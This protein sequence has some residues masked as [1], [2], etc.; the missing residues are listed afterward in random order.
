RDAVEHGG[1]TDADE[2]QARARRP[3]AIGQSVD[4]ESHGETG[5]DRDD[6]HPGATESEHDDGEGRRGA[7]A[8]ADADDVGARARIAQHRLEGDATE[9]EADAGDH[10]ED[11]A[12]KPQ[13]ADREVRAGHVLSEDDAQ[14]VRGRIER[15]A[16][17]QT[18]REGRD[19]EGCEHGDDETASASA[20]YPARGEVVDAGVD[21]LECGG[22]SSRSF[23]RRT[24]Y[25]KKGAPM[26]AVMMPTSISA[27][28]A[29]M[30]PTTS[31]AVSSP[32]PTRAEKGSSH[33]LSMPMS[34]RHR[35]G[36]TR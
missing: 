30:R 21:G 19:H 3:A 31:A 10:R 4:Q 5:D 7:R 29:T 15:P 13:A 33:R 16:E 35:C 1:D 11:R 28:R 36:T 6:R 20:P 12:G 24:M 27:G 22:H 34:N 9:A 25:T 8:G 17:H 14:H 32:A 18:R 23:C 2:D 26:S